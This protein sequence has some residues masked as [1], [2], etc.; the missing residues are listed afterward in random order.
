MTINSETKK[1]FKLALPLILQQLF[2]QF[3]IWADTA[4]LGH[5]NSQYFSALANV[6]VPFDVVSSIL[7]AM[8]TGT[9]I[10]VAQ[11]IGAG[12]HEAARKYSEASYVGNTIF[13]IIAFFIIYFGAESIFRFMGIE[14][15]ILEFSVSYI[16]IIAFVVLTIGIAGTSTSILQG[17]GITKV[18][19]VAGIVSNVMNVVL[20]Y[21]LIFGKG[22][23]P[24]MNIEGA[25][26]ATAISNFAAIPISLIYILRSSKIPFKIRFKNI[27]RF[28]P[29]IYK[30]VLIFGLP[31][32]AEYL[33]WNIGCFVLLIYMNRLSSDA[34][35]IYNLVL[36]I[37]FLPLMIYTGFA[38]AGLTL[39]G[40]KT[41]EENTRAAIRIGFKCL[42]YA[43]IVCGIVAIFFVIIPKPILSCFTDDKAFVEKCVP[44]LRFMALV[45]CPRALNNVLGPGI[46]ALGDTN[47]MLYTQ[48]FGTI[49]TCS[50]AYVLIFHT[51]LGVMGIFITFFADE[52]LRGIINTLRFGKGREVFGFK[53][54]VKP[55]N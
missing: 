43:F 6:F 11:K 55:E 29:S 24:E 37:E 12:D 44:Y 32:G 48:I 10:L 35:G 52:L 38:N 4:M 13:S 54:F 33:L 40:Q 7:Y 53:P 17:I 41:G 15:P 3:L 45:L 50:F 31:S 26:L 49:F 28:K 46:R 39:V 1:I 19:M 14:S 23:F 8:C 5:V 22:P 20:D 9:T 42:K 51:S 27:I 25:A 30:N 21:L 16:R 18:I 34:A 47:W 36:S 2:A